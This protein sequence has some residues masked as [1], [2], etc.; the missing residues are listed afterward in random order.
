MSPPMMRE[1][2]PE[3][4]LAFW[5]G[6]P[7]PESAD[8][9]LITDEIDEAE[10]AKR[11]KALW[12][13]KDAAV[14][15]HMR[16]R[17]AACVSGALTGH[18][19]T[20]AA[21]ARGRLALILLCDQ[22]TRNIYRDTPSA[23]KGDAYALAHA[24]AG[25]MQGQDYDLRLIERVFFYMPFEHSEQLADQDEAVRLMTALRTTAPKVDQSLYAGYVDYAIAHQ[26]IIARFGRFPHRNAILG[27]T[28]S[29]EEIDFLQTPGSSF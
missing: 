7:D 28:S 15:A 12:W 25:R 1:E 29:A 21:S 10:V 3:S 6:Y 4:I 2:T 22:F 9:M 17:F 13:A 18:L 8:D 14:D 20:W 26:R 23:F 19:D 11:Q 5:F 24:R 27:R 16:Q